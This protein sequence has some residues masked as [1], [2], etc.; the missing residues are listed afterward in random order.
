MSELSTEKWIPPWAKKEQK[1]QLVQKTR[2]WCP[3]KSCKWNKSFR[4]GA[5]NVKLHL[6]SD[7]RLKC[8]TYTKKA[9]F[10]KKLDFFP[11]EMMEAWKEG[12]DSAPKPSSEAPIIVSTALLDNSDGQVSTKQESV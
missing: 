10:P 8:D 9:G 3:L 1:K 5:L 4:C 7:G 6:Y 11:D 12:Q 2:I